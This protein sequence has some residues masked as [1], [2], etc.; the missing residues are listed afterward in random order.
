MPAIYI[1]DKRS[2]PHNRHCNLIS[3]AQTLYLNT[4]SSKITSQKVLAIRNSHHRKHLRR[5]IQGNNQYRSFS[6]AKAATNCF[7]WLQNTRFYESQGYYIRGRIPPYLLVVKDHKDFLAA[8]IR[9]FDSVIIISPP[10]AKHIQF[11]CLQAT[12]FC[13]SQDSQICGRRLPCL[14]VL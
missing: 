12:R 5:L 10:Y 2:I 1:Y 8:P 14:F 3:G 11:L 13:E 9:L 6:L 4:L 7:L